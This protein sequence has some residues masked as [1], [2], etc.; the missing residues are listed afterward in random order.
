MHPGMQASHLQ[1]LQ[2]HLMSRGSPYLAAQAHSAALLPAAA[3]AAAAAAHGQHPLFGIPP[4]TGLTLDRKE[5]GVSR[6][7]R[8]AAELAA[9]GQVLRGVILISRCLA[10]ECQQACVGEK[11]G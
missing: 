6:L 9:S 5:V 7:G 3:A 8:A 11:P 2:A 4:Y 1:Q 10:S